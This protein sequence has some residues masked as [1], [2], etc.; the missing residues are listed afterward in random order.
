M[1]RKG[2]S[3]LLVFTMSVILCACSGQPQGTSGGS[4]SSAASE[5]AGTD[6]TPEIAEG[7]N[8]VTI[9]D[10]TGREVTISGEVTRVVAVSASDCEIL[11]A[12]GAG[13]LLVGR[14]EYCDYPAEVM[15]L[16]AVQSGAD[17]NIEQIIALGP[18]VV[19]MSTMAQT[20]EQIHIF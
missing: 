11:Y 1:K 6:G 19:F 10:M 18:Q 13:D 12:V 2:L 9:T 4:A 16:P 17:T 14:G 8:T 7:E 5:A 20:T 3:L 15:E